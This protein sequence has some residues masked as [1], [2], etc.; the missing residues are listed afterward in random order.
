MQVQDFGH[1]LRCIRRKR[2]A[3]QGGFESDEPVFTASAPRLTQ[4]ISGHVLSPPGNRAFQWTRYL[5]WK[6]VSLIL[7][8]KTALLLEYLGSLRTSVLSIVEELEGKGS[9]VFYW[10]FY[11]QTARYSVFPVC[12]FFMYLIKYFL[13]LLDKLHFHMVQ[14][15]SKS[16]N[17][18]SFQK[19]MMVNRFRQGIG[20][21][22]RPIEFYKTVQIYQKPHYCSVLLILLYI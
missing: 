4:S 18:L 16:E 5:W 15:R 9:V 10:C 21:P 17:I 22:H 8:Q 19:Y 12:F 2:N 6:S 13:K 1:L 20:K 7:N 3:K 14:I 11:P